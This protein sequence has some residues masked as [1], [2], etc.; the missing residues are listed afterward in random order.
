M[1]KKMKELNFIKIAFL[2][3]I[4]AIIIEVTFSLFLFMLSS[5]S[6]FNYAG[7]FLLVVFAEGIMTVGVYGDL[8]DKYYAV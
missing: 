1:G 5:P 4:P 2:C 8:W 6:E 7:L 3:L